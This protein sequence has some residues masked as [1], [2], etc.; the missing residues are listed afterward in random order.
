[1]PKVVASRW[2]GF[3]GEGLEVE[4]L[5]AADGPVVGITLRPLDMALFAAG[6]AIYDCRLPQGVFRINEP[7]LAMRGIYRGGYDTLHLHIPNRVIAEFLNAES[8]PSRSSTPSLASS[9]PASDPVIDRLGQALL[10][11]DDFGGAF[12]QCYADSIGL[13]I[14]ARLLG[15][16]AEAVRHRRAF[17]GWRSGG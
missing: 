9:Q 6:K 16:T 4:T 5:I 1:M 8:G 14:V 15:R 12:D 13:A 10:H 3:A 2:T 11:A 17:P 7:G